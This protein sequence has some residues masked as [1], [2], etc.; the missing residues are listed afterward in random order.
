MPPQ[1]WEEGFSFTGH[2]MWS[3]REEPTLD[4]SMIDSKSSVV[5][6]STYI[7]LGDSGARIPEES[8]FLKKKVS[9][10]RGPLYILLVQGFVNSGPAPVLYGVLFEHSHAPIYMSISSV[11]CLR[12]LSAA[13]LYGCN[14]CYLLLYT[15]N[16]L[17]HI[18]IF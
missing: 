13:E 3:F 15:R 5:S 16:L 14:F 6:I 11:Y 2:A 12:L 9:L 8:P 18:S 7:H 17:I 1:S 4:F 10:K